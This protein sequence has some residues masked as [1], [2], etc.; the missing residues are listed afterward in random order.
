MDS[1]S[2][3]SMNSALIH[4]L[5]WTIPTASSGVTPSASLYS[6][7]HFH[8]PW[9]FPPSKMTSF[10]SVVLN[11]PTSP[12]NCVILSSA[13]TAPHS[14]PPTSFFPWTAPIPPSP[15]YLALLLFAKH[16]TCFQA[17]ISLLIRTKMVWE[18]E[19][20]CSCLTTD[21][22]QSQ[23]LNPGVL[24]CRVHLST[25]HQTI[26]CHFYPKQCYFLSR[27][28][29]ILP[30]LW[31]LIFL[32]T[33]SPLHYSTFLCIVFCCSLHV[34]DLSYYTIS[35]YREVCIKQAILK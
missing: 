16:T 22:Y 20:K 2:F 26:H 6:K 7:Q 28:I 23:S 25:P 8:R 10:H 24:G 19:A 29:L 35:F 27:P 18:P 13:T 12:H 34:S 14:I 3:L 15:L 9:S 30:L 5:T 11:L 32:A 31:I 1:L 17:F 21:M 4:S 33:P